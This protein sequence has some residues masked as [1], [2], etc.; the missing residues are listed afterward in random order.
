MI[1]AACAWSGRSAQECRV[2]LSACGD[3]GR[4]PAHFGQPSRKRR[5]L[6]FTNDVEHLGETCLPQSGRV[7]RNRAAQQLIQEHPERIQIG[8]L[9]D[10]SGHHL[11]LLRTGLLR[12]AH[13]L[14]KL[15]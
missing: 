4:R 8:A 2:G 12:C 13:H 5:S 11:C 7:E 3:I 1:Q 9:I 15:R 14:T 10:I 6:L